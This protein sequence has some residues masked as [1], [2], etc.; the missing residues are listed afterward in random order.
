[1]RY[2]KV[3]IRKSIL[4]RCNFTYYYLPLCYQKS[5]YL[6]TNLLKLDMI[7]VKS[8]KFDFIPG[9]GFFLTRLKI[10]PVCSIIVSS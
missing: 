8:Y 4:C 10:K 5:K 6:L 7:I 1:M 3:P 9:K 2:V